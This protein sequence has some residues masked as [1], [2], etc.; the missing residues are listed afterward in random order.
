M[1][2]T[3]RTKEEKDFCYAM[4]RI[5]Y[6]SEEK[7]HE[8]YIKHKSLIENDL[9]CKSADLSYNYANDTQKRFP[10]GEE[11][12]SKSAEKSYNYAANVLHGRFDL[13]ENKIAKSP[14]FSYCY[15]RD[16]IKGRWE[17]AEKTLLACSN[18]HII[19][20]VGYAKEVIKG[21]W[22]E[23]E[24]IIKNSG[25]PRAI[26][27]YLVNARCEKWDEVEELAVTG[28][29]QIIE[30]C[31]KAI[32]GRWHEGENR[33]LSGAS[34]DSCIEYCQKVLKGR[35]IDFENKMFESEDTGDIFE[36]AKKVMNGKLPELLHN[37]VLML[38]MVHKDEFLE[39]YFKA[40]KYKTEKK[41][42]IYQ[43]NS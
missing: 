7:L 19:D 24:E 18:K 41:L 15:A 8:F 31:E 43:T 29:N 9:I 17:Q 21:K 5:R 36:Y 3:T 20:I 23:A 32:K 10:Q 1:T 12:I 39:K 28:Y 38:G 42:K 6:L 4:N 25:N 2:T 30:Y 16:V 11:A 27:D 34:P 22:P 14:D 26:Y 37:K 35:W 13:G 33:L 40:K